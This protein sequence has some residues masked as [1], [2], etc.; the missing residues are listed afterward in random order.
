[1]AHAQQIPLDKV[2][3][4]RSQPPIKPVPLQALG[5]GR[6]GGSAS[7]VPPGERDD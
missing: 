4:L 7:V 2:G 3:R 6:S 1:L 5:A